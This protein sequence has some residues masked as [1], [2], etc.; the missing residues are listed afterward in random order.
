MPFLE[1]SS[2]TVN[3]DIFHTFRTHFMI[4]TIQKSR[5]TSTKNSQDETKTTENIA[6]TPAEFSDNQKQ[7]CTKPKV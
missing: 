4:P 5:E 6:V 7:K 2:D 1:N 3:P